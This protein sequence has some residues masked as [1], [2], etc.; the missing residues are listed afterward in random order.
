MKH[1]G[2]TPAKFL[3][4]S[5]GCELLHGSPQ[6]GVGSTASQSLSHTN[7]CRIAHLVLFSDPC[8]PPDPLGPRLVVTCP[9]S[10]LKS[11][12]FAGGD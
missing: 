1:E 7:T 10:S 3:A 6:S 2:G 9:G 12:V 11:S 8:I 5:E 4:S